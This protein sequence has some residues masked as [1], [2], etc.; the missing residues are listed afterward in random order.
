[1]KFKKGD[2]VIVPFKSLGIIREVKNI[3]WGYPYIVE[4]LKENA[5][6][7]MGEKQDFKEEQ[8]KLLVL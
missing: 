4:I 6:Y 8:L 3:I 2:I 5:F 7:D 1:M